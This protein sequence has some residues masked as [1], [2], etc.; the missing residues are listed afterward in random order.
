MF[1]LLW[2]YLLLRIPLTFVAAAM[3]G[4]AATLSIQIVTL[5]IPSPSSSSLNLL[6]HPPFGVPRLRYHYSVRPISASNC[7]GVLRL[8]SR[9]MKVYRE[10]VYMLWSRKLL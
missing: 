9:T 3:I 8:S 7:C 5:S 10:Q 2:A 4:E 1:L 6:E